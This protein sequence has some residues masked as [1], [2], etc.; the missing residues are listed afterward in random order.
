MNKFNASA[1][2]WAENFWKF[3]KTLCWFHFFYFLLFFQKE[4]II[5]FKV[6]FL[7]QIM[8]WSYETLSSL[9]KNHFWYVTCQYSYI[10]SIWTFF[11]NIGVIFFGFF[12]CFFRAF[13]CSNTPPRDP[14]SG[15]F[16]FQQRVNLK[17]TLYARSDVVAILI[18]VKLWFIFF[19]INILSV[20]LPTLCQLS[21][22]T[23][24]PLI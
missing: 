11:S 24:Y 18:Q 22:H 23:I 10:D 16:P 4:K 5:I 15:T 6:K 20:S 12:F 7:T 2:M 17:L 13:S 19:P 8:H 9:M 14:I 1:Q 3:L 21:R